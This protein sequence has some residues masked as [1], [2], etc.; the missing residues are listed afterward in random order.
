MSKDDQFEI[1]LLVLRRFQEKRILKELMLI[2]SWCL[3]F[4]RYHFENPEKLP[5]FRTLDVDF[6]IPHA[7]KIKTEANIPEIL[8]NE[9][10][11]SIYNRA[12]DIV[13]YNHKELQV[14]F[15]VPE[16]GRGGE[17]SREIK[18]LHIKAIALRYLNM[19]LDRPLLVHYEGL[20]VRVPEPAAFAL[21]KLI[22]SEER[23]NKEKQKSD[24]ETALGLLDYLYGKPHEV[25]RI[26]T[27]LKSLP[28]SWVET[29]HS[30]AEKRYPKL[31]E[32][33]GTLK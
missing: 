17:R 24:L 6:L 31:A 5:A 25:S 12:S 29:I 3:Q 10:F 30:I 28:K 32:T 20:Q 33:G 26:K 1:L 11:V 21:H 16:L 23:K 13:K 18:N 14:E 4:Y 22:V 2:G 15:L 19:L 7:S 27:I 8:K 9:G